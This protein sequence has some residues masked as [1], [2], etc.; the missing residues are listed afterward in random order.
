MNKEM[1][2]TPEEMEL[3]KNKFAGDEKFIKLLR[4]LF[5]PEITPDA[6]LGQNIDLWMTVKIEDLTPEQALINLKAR[7]TVISHVEAMLMQIRTLAGTTEETAE[8]TIKRLK[9]D[10]AQ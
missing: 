9:A 2:I 5:L 6:P 7:N 1:R 10:S 4:K 3:L 8:E